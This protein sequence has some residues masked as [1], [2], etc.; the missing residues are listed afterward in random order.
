MIASEDAAT[1]LAQN[2]ALPVG[3]RETAPPHAVQ[4]P[5]VVHLVDQSREVD[6]HEIEADLDIDV[7]VWFE[8]DIAELEQLLSRYAAF[9][10]WLSE[11]KTSTSSG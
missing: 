11:R 4:P 7:S 6:V 2:G 9:D 5:A 8:D 3:S 10:L 1:V